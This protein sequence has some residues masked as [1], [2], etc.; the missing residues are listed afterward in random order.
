MSAS[1][2]ISPGP[3]KQPYFFCAI[4]RNTGSQIL[5]SFIAPI[6]RRR[7]PG[8][9]TA[10]RHQPLPETSITSDVLCGTVTDNGLFMVAV[11]ENVMRFSTLRGATNGGITCMSMP[12]P[13]EWRSRLE[14]A[15]NNVSGISISVK[16][17]QGREPPGQII[18]SAVD[19]RGHFLSM[20]VSVSEMP[21]TASPLIRQP[22]RSELSTDVDAAIRELM[23]EPLSGQS[24][25]VSR[26][27]MEGGSHATHN[28]GS[29]S[30]INTEEDADLIKIDPS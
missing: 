5:C 21:A 29:G 7:Q 17:P 9:M 8:G 3:S 4:N 11:E 1:L 24:S 6:E 18:V 28:R 19:C 23:G 27:T 10:A 26:S 16:E 20:R 13:L 15:T 22:R 30:T 2:F 14:P 25:R 12:L